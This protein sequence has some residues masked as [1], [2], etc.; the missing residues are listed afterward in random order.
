MNWR[1]GSFRSSSVSS[2][3][4]EVGMGASRG[5]V[6]IGAGG[7]ARE[8]AIACKRAIDTRLRSVVAFAISGPVSVPIEGAVP[9]LTIDSA[10]A[11]FPGAWFVVGVGDPAT[12]ASLAQQAVAVG[13]RAATVIDERAH[14]ADDVSIADGA[15]VFAGAV[16]SAGCRLGRHAHVNYNASVSHDCEIGDYS[17]VSP[18][19][20]LAGNVSIGSHVLVGV[21]A[22]V[23]HGTPASKLVIGAHAVVGAGS[24]VTKHIPEREVWA[25][26]PARRL[27]AVRGESA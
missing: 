7:H 16:V 20:N 6:V 11:Q 14:V 19:A 5:I 25:G 3:E 1:H 18:G 8:V 15:V 26:V 2:R 9:V 27:R 13:W 17:L 4:S 22:T 24:V 21:G 12:R 10:A 23:L